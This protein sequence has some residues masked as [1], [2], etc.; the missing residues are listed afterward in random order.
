MPFIVKRT[1]FIKP[2]IPN[3]RS[4][5]ALYTLQLSRDHH[6]Q[7]VDD[8]NGLVQRVE[9]EAGLAERRM[10]QRLLAVRE[11]NHARNLRLRMHEDIERGLVQF[12]LLQGRNR[13]WWYALPANEYH[14]L[15]CGCTP[16]GYRCQLCRAL[17]NCHVPGGTCR[18]CDRFI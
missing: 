8:D 4:Y 2:I 7:H 15:Y 11:P 1:R 5:A 17:C 16:T 9:W 10:E 18:F 3:Y 14:L 12:D 13:W 6:E